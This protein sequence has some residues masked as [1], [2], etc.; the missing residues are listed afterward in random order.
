[1]GYAVTLN[2]SYGRLRVVT[3]R[4]LVGEAQMGSRTVLKRVI[5]LMFIRMRKLRDVHYGPYPTVC[6]VYTEMVPPSKRCVTLAQVVLH[7]MNIGM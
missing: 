1:M 6:R 2:F 5:E 3:P 4:E 7:A